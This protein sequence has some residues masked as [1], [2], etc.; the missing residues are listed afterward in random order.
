VAGKRAAALFKAALTNQGSFCTPGLHPACAKSNGLGVEHILGDLQLSRNWKE[1]W[2]RAYHQR[3]R[4]LDFL[5]A[6][7][8]G[9]GHS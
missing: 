8:G 2:L 7:D 9:C 3:G 1:S 6:Y 5:P 4:R